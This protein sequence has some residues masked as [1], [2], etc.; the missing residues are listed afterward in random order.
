M[1]AHQFSP[2]QGGNW[3]DHEPLT[4]PHSM[5]TPHKVRTVSSGAGYKYLGVGE[6]GDA[7]V[8]ETLLRPK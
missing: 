4:T 7:P 2:V 1:A 3:P 6:R 8:P 5:T